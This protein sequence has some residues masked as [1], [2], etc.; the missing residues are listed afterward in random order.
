[1]Y[2]E[3]LSGYQTDLLELLNEALFDSEH[4]E[5]VVVRNIQFYSLCEH[6]LL[7]FFGQAHVAYL[8]DRKIIGLSKIPRL[9]EMYARRLQVQERLTTQIAKSLWDLVQ[10]R[11]VAVL[12]EGAHLCAM[13]RGVKQDEAR[14]LTSSRLGVFKTDENMYQ[15]F[16]SQ[17]SFRGSGNQF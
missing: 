16:L 4:S 1:M 5:L 6:H 12:V 11:G 10:P 8:P 7:P 2:R 3:L 15:N 14:M 17:V 9:V 13:M